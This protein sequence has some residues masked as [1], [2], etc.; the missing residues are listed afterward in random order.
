MA[1]REVDD[2]SV[3]GSESEPIDRDVIANLLGGDDAGIGEILADLI[4][5]FEIEARAK[6]AA[7]RAAVKAPD[8]DAIHRLAHSLKGG[9]G[10]M[11][12]REVARLSRELES[13]D[14]S[15]GEEGVLAEQL[16]VEVERAI[17]GLRR[18]LDETR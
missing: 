12:A 17:A 8:V 13:K 5:T 4:A 16:A 11:G 7:I 14:A 3:P 9:S 6:V 1:D 15:P 10:S 2:P 18:W